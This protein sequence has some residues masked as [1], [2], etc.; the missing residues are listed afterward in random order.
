[1][2][3]KRKI[4]SLTTYISILALLAPVLAVVL[5]QPANAAT[6]T[7]TYI[8]L[9]RMKSG[10]GTTFR[11]VFK[12]ASSQTA[13]VAVDFN[14]TDVGAAQWTN[15]TPGGLV[16]SGA[17]TTSTAQCV[18]DG[19]TALPGVTSATGAGSVITTSG[20][21]ATTSGTSYCVDFT[22][23]AAVTTP[24]A[25]HEGEYH[26]TITQGT[27]STTVAVR[28]IAGD[29][30]VVTATVPPTFNFVLSGTTDTFSANLVSA[31]YTST[32][33]KTVTITTNA[34]NGWIAWVKDL[35]G[36]SGASTKGA[37][38][39]ATASNYTIPTTN[40]NALGSASHTALGAGTE[41]YGL[42]VTVTTNNSGS[43]SAD[44]AYDGSS[45]KL[46]VLDPTNFRRAAF[47]TGPANGDVITL[48]ER[49]QIAGTTPAAND[50]TDTLTVVGA[51]NF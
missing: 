13:Q 9:N 33:G 15:A 43:V 41:D 32:A 11:V 8:R 22:T 5:S 25:G 44:A 2:S 37:L 31:S 42:G 40:A 19:F 29:Q 18:T 35:N 28:I 6:L 51:G 47:N 34:T 16:T 12:A 27:D 24:T 50:Y 46:G 36:S 17:V 14:G 38:K 48:T 4:S 45:S 1:M 26:P 30:I 23:A 20:V 10:T 39:S 49:A 7:N 21:T 3:L